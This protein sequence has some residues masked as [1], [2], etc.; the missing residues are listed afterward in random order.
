[1]PLNPTLHGRLDR[2]VPGGVR[3]IGKPGQ[4][5]MAVAGRSVV[6]MKF[7]TASGGEEY[8]VLCPFCNDKRGH[9]YVNYR[10]GIYDD[11]TS[12]YN[13]HL[14]KCF[15]RNCLNDSQHRQTFWDMVFGDF[16]VDRQRTLK[17]QIDPESN[18]AT[19]TLC[20]IPAPGHILPLTS[21]PTDHPVVVYLE[22]RGY[23][24]AQ[25]TQLWRLGVCVSALDPMIEGR[26]YIPIYQ[27]KVLVGWQARWPADIDFKTRNIPKYYNLRGMPK[28]LMLYNYDLARTCPLAVICEGVSDVWRIGPPGVALLGKTITPPQLSLLANAWQ[29]RVIIILLDSNDP[30]A[31][32]QS[33]ILERSVGTAVPGASVLNVR[34]PEGLDPGSCS[35][36]LIWSTIRKAGNERGLTVNYAI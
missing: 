3:K 9:L 12:T 18:L 15:R 22:G 1:M 26:I 6:T 32:P 10:Y 14:A 36:E 33:Q 21:L 19:P 16:S 20:E 29:N 23:D 2:R 31:G 27:D 4:A 7:K 25:L 8:I 24:I 11:N 34:L 5:A 35:S 30:D 13:Q 17:V 28:R